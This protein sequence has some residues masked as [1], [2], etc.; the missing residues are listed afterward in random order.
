MTSVVNLVSKGI[1]L[2]SKAA[3]AISTGMSIYGSLKEG[4]DIKE[5]AAYNAKIAK[6][7]AEAVKRKAAYDESVHRE[8]IRSFVSSQRSIIGAS[9][10]QIEGSPELAI[11]DA[12]EKGEL[13]ALAI[14]EGATS[15]AKRFESEAKLSKLAGETAVTQSRFKAG[16]TLLS[17]L[18]DYYN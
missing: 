2:V 7:D 9:G 16:S 14:R 15:D 4:E 3:P 8:R 5:A 12:I 6:E 13:D 10:V 17:G 11:L 1:G 18:A